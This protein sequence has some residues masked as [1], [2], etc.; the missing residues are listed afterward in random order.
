MYSS[1]CTVRLTFRWSEI[2][3]K[4]ELVLIVTFSYKHVVHTKQTG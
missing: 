3:L 1:T 4:M 2:L